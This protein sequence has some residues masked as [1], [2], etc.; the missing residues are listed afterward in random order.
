VAVG[1]V[2]EGKKRGRSADDKESLYSEERDA[3][4][5]VFGQESD[6]KA[7]RFD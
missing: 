5:T 1:D 7:R 3:V 6:S 2:V 4:W